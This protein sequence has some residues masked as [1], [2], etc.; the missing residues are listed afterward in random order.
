MAL[1]NA[2]T[3]V[4]PEANIIYCH[5]HLV[6][7][8]KRWI[9]LAKGKKDDVTVLCD[10][11]RIIIQSESEE[12]LEQK[13]AE[14]EGKW[15]QDYKNYVHS[16]LL[17]DIKDR[18][19]WYHV[20]R[21]GAFAD[22]VAT[23][24]ISESLHAVIKNHNDY[25]SLQL[26]TLVMQLFNLQL[27]YLGEFDR[28]YRGHGDYF[29]KPQF[30]KSPA[31]VEIPEYTYWKPEEFIAFFKDSV[32][33]P[34]SNIEKDGD[35]LQ[36][37]TG[38]A[39]IACDRNLVSLDSRAAA[40]HVQ[41][42][43]GN[44]AGTVTRNDN[45]TFTCTCNSTGF[46]YHRRAVLH[47]VRMEEGEDTFT[48]DLST[49]TRKGRGFKPGSKSRSRKEFMTNV[50]AAPDAD[51]NDFDDSDVSQN[52]SDN[53]L[54]DTCSNHSGKNSPAVANTHSRRHSITSV[55]SHS[56]G[57]SDA[58]LHHY[59]TVTQA[60]HTAVDSQSVTSRRS[61]A[62]D[63][64]TPEVYK[65]GA[66]PEEALRKIA[67]LL[68]TPTYECM[69]PKRLIM[70]DIINDM[71]CLL[72][73]IHGLVDSVAFIDSVEFRGMESRSHII[74]KTAH[75]VEALNSDVIIINILKQSHYVLAVILLRSKEVIIID[76]MVGR[77]FD[78]EEL[79][80]PTM[81]FIAASHV[82]AGVAFDSSGW[83]FILETAI[84]EQDN[85]YDCGI[86]ACMN[87]YAIMRREPFYPRETFPD[88]N[89]VR[90]WITF[91]LSSQPSL[92]IILKKNV[93][94]SRVPADERLR[95]QAALDAIIISSEEIRK[96]SSWQSIRDEIKTGI[97]EWNECSAP[98][99]PGNHDG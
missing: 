82:V 10:D 30:R 53:D 12:E 28:A 58:G 24:N 78:V 80:Q 44:E 81:T 22:K 4:F 43:Y 47:A 83:R 2:I 15:S 87:A 23:T 57:L 65:F 72:I 93:K 85:G 73:K 52:I 67:K 84:A 35:Y 89:A 39:K 63:P 54:S 70:E 37:V 34:K 49:L 8:C 18:A 46:C 56:S 48:Y 55:H 95:R 96:Q 86:H 16:E 69:K 91:C 5:N 99:C 27:Y 14:R 75:R 33:M 11:L 59:V 17:P 41:G 71:V 79:W 76:S 13:V 88:S 50:T 97:M 21:F 90:R 61:L 1:P 42:L 74:L 6:Q 19:A 64:S 68:T 98:N 7:D 51:E 77:V 31:L 66:L 36:G 94:A 9:K 40:F 3:H 32:Y 29:R 26:D 20:R 38:L 60:S 45:G 92:P 62:S 25:K